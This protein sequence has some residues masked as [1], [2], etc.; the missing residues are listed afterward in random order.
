MRVMEREK[1]SRR[2]ERLE[3]RVSRA[4]KALIQK[5]ADLQGRSVTILS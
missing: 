5:A 3:A 2:E 1:E 4:T